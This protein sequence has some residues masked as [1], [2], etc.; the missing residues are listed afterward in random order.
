MA[1]KQPRL[2]SGAGLSF[3]PTTLMGT[4]DAASSCHQDW[5]HR[6]TT[7]RPY[8][9]VGTVLAILFLSVAAAYSTETDAREADVPFGGIVPNDWTLLPRAPDSLGRR[10]VSPSGDAWLWYFAVPA[11]AQGGPPTSQGR[12]TY[13]ARGGDWIVTSG[14]RGNRIFYRRAMLA[15]NNTKWRQIEFEYP[16]SEKRL[17]D[18]FVTRTSLSLR[19]Y[20]EAGC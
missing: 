12:V 8:R 5:T 4:T 11:N 18:S 1:V 6:L 14:Y 3:A 19:A 9:P 13:Q 2:R 20:K 15:C 17:F 10:F 7:V 16:A